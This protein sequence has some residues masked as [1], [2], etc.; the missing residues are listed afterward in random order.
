MQDEYLNKIIPSITVCMGT[1]LLECEV[2]RSQQGVLNYHI[3]SIVLD[4]STPSPNSTTRWRS[5]SVTKTEISLHFSVPAV[6]CS[7][8]S[9]LIGSFCLVNVQTGSALGGLSIREC[10]VQMW[11]GPSRDLGKAG[12]A[13]GGPGPHLEQLRSL[14]R[15]T[16]S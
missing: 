13:P 9:L 3:T 5:L 16:R 4:A 14:R 11:A 7:K 2:L 12:V 1:W 10:C 15:G 6:R 8:T